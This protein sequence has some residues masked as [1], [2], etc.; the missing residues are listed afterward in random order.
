MLTTTVVCSVLEY[1][2]SYILEKIFKVRWWDYEDKKFNINGRICLEMA[3]PFGL[4]GLIVIY[5]LFPFVNHILS[6]L[7]NVLIYLI[8]VIIL[9]LFII[10]LIL[11]FNIILKFK[12][13]AF[14]ITKDSTEEI[15]NFVKETLSKQ[16]K[17]VKRLVDSFPDYKLDFDKIK[18]KI[19]KRK[20]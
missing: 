19:L 5:I 9:I 14:R 16:S 18:N 17:L 3:V 7:P 15:S 4:L 20:N 6:L 1:F 13:S 12:T 10:D 8:T 11:S 2:A